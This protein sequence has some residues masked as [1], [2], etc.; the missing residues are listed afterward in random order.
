MTSSNFI[1]LTGQKIGRLTVKRRA[2][3]IV[4]KEVRRKVA[5]YC[6]CD[7]GTKD[8]VTTSNKLRLKS[9]KYKSCG[10][11]SKGNRFKPKRNKYYKQ[12]DY[13]VF[14]TNN[15]DKFYVDNEDVDIVKEHTW[16]ISH[17]Y[18]MDRDGVLLHRM[19]LNSP[20]DMD[21]DH[22]NHD[23]L[24]NRKNNLRITT[25]SQNMW[26]QKLAKN[27]TSGAT[28][29]SRIK[30]NKWKARIK[31]NGNEHYLGSFDT[32]NEALSARKQAE[33]LYF[34]EYSYN[35]SM[36]GGNNIEWI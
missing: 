34:G 22:I 26:N 8:F 27:N 23:K 32:F 12:D 16:F 21:V 28:G 11:L 17:G 13:T 30:N 10:C 9:N 3:D 36:K 25:T 31:E 7:C 14:V 24:D 4:D 5:W 6:D 33:E 20:Q 19:L 2:P 35:N 1:D 29:V 15:G 18:V